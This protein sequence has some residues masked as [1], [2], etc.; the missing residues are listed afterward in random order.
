[1]HRVATKVRKKRQ[2]TGADQK[3]DGW[4]TSEEQQVHNGRGRHKIGGND[5]RHLQKATSCSGW[6]KPS[7]NQ[8]NDT[9]NNITTCSYST[10]MN[11]NISI[12]GPPSS[13]GRR[14]QNIFKM[15][16]IINMTFTMTYTQTNASR[17][18]VAL[19]LT[20]STGSLQGAFCT[21]FEFDSPILSTTILA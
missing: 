13:R 11:S 1:M 10:N 17:G 7:S 16:K 8:L 4:M 3:Q 12:I 18:S 2:P 14:N 21:G 19:R 20:N 15:L 5:G 9:N 6:T